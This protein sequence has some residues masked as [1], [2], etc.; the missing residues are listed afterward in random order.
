MVFYTTGQIIL[1]EALMLILPTIVS[2]IYAEDCGYSFLLTMAI[3]A[4]LGG[5]LV[6][7]LKPSD[8]VIYAKE[9]FLTVALAWLAL[10]A[11][12]AS[13]LH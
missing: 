3:A 13:T 4:V 8:H 11:I 5:L 1:F 7:L 9:G 2:F 10:S 12:G 6:L